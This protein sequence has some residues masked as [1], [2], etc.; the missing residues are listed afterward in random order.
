MDLA[1]THLISSIS[2]LS[3]LNGRSM[4]FAEEYVILPDGIFCG[5]YSTT[6]RGFDGCVQ[7]FLTKLLRD[8]QGPSNHFLD[9]KNVQLVPGIARLECTAIM[10][11]CLP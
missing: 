7:P 4:T 1:G 5:I 8:L 2:L 9:M 10:T 3:V 11:A 6:V